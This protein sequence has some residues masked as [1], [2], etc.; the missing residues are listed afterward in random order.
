MNAQSKDKYKNRMGDLAKSFHKIWKFRSALPLLTTTHCQNLRINDQKPRKGILCSTSELLSQNF[1]I[2]IIQAHDSSWKA[3]SCF[4]YHSEANC[5]NSYHQN[6]QKLKKKC[7]LINDQPQSSKN[8][9][10]RKYKNQFLCK[11]TE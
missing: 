5:S 8:L 6:G 10:E 7:I 4:H 1:L 9:K 11:A 2:M 3:I